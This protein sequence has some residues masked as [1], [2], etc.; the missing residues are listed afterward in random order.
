M[1]SHPGRVAPNRPCAVLP[2]DTSELTAILG[3]GAKILLLSPPTP[4][5]RLSAM[6]PS[7]GTSLSFGTTRLLFKVTQAIPMAVACD[8]CWLASNL[9]VETSFSW[10]DA[11]GVFESSNNGG[12]CYTCLSH[13][14]RDKSSSTARRLSL[15]Y[16]QFN[17]ES[18]A[19]LRT[20]Q[21]AAQQT[22]S[23]SNTKSWGKNPQTTRLQLPWSMLDSQ[24]SKCQHR[25]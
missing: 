20:V 13:R 17:M 24:H 8:E 10:R 18:R 4:F 3:I 9:K 16:C 6:T 5:C 21:R 2:I 23:R 25:F 19:K 15:E 11:N 12:G 22:T 14:Q 1:T 7:D